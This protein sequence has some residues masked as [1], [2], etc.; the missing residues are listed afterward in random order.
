VLRLSCLTPL[1]C[2]TRRLLLQQ[3]IYFSACLKD[4]GIY[5]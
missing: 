4:K 3:M 2:K 5:F 1:K